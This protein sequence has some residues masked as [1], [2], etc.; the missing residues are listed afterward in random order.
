M[1]LW[2]VLVHCL[3]ACPQI[4]VLAKLFFAAAVNC[5]QHFTLNLLFNL[6]SLIEWTRMAISLAPIDKKRS[7][8]VAHKTLEVSDLAA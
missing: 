4:L 1:D 7:L 6:V 2:L 5:Q 8:H 3:L